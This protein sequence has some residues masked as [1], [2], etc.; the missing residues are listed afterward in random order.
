MKV[1]NPSVFSNVFYESPKLK[2]WMCE[3]CTFSQIWSQLYTKVMYCVCRLFVASRDAISKSLYDRL[4]RWIVNRINQLLAP[5]AEDIAVAKEIGKTALDVC[6]CL[7][8]C[9][10]C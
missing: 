8:S 3:L 1:S 2:N 9:E 4:F 10:F 6:T 7:Y 5:S